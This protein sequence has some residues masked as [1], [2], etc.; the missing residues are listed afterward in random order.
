MRKQKYAIEELRRHTI[1][2]EIPALTS[3]TQKIRPYPSELHDSIQTQTNQ[4][5][6]HLPYQCCL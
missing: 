5:K 3:A 6:D 1:C 4:K 2:T